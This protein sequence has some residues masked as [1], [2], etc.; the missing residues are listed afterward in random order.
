MNITKDLRY[1]KTGLLNYYRSRSN[2]ILSELSLQYS[3]T[4]FKKRASEINKAIIKSKENI[5]SI[6]FN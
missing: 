1:N 3:V 2:E 5:L 6:L 4:D